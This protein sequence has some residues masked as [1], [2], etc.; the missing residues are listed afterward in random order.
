MP[1]RQPA[2]MWGKVGARPFATKGGVLGDKN[3]LPFR[4]WLGGSSV[5]LRQ[6]PHPAA[7]QRHGVAAQAAQI[8]SRTPRG[9]MWRA[10]I[11]R[12]G[13]AHL[14]WPPDERTPTRRPKGR[15][16]RPTC[17]QQ[18]A[19]GAGC[20]AGPWTLQSRWFTRQCAGAAQVQLSPPGW[21]C[22]VC[23]SRGDRS[24]PPTAPAERKL[25]HM[26]AQAAE[27]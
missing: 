18:C 7:K 9:A 5:S 12:G 25:H 3:L 10:A 6:Y 27:P 24:A 8:F 21:S 20:A 16:A 26:V 11:E 15:G 13:S 2:R 14:K 1:A 23:P 19:G 22:S 4:R 17:K